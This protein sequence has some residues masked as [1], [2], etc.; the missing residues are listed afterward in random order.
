MRKLSRKKPNRE[1][2]IKNL[3]ASLVLYETI[4]TT[5]SKAKEVKSFLEKVIA[6]HKSGDLNDIRSINAIFFDKIAAKKMI[7]EL[8]SRYQSRSSGFIRSFRLKNRLGDNAE[9][10]RLELIDK[11]VFT[12][13]DKNQDSLDK[14]DVKIKTTVKGKVKENA[15]K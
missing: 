11:K 6:R 7:E 14:E 8:I 4:E 15:G 10:M 3:A 13:K 5:E 1:H 9:M 2:M 12:N